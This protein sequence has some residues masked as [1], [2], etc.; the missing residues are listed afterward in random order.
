MIG[1]FCSSK[2]DWINQ[3][4]P[5]QPIWNSLG[6]ADA[7]MAWTGKWPTTNWPLRVEAASWRGQPVFFSLV[8][9][10]TKPQ[11]AKGDER[12]RGEKILTIAGIILL[13]SVILGA[14]FLARRNYR[15]GRSDTEGA[16]RLAFVMFALE[17]AL[18]LFRSH[19]VA[20]LQT[21][22]PAD[23]RQHRPSHPGITWM[24]YRD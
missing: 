9:E 24:L 18:W 12:T 2:P 16:T 4:Q 23:C 13:L 3:F 21:F 8:G 17:M 22:S 14:I 20:G 1:T 6:G 15:L 7:R 10:W 11:R 5:T 19:I